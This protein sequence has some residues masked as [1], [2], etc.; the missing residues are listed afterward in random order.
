MRFEDRQIELSDAAQ[1]STA[2]GDSALPAATLA[3]GVAYVT[4]EDGLEAIDTATGK[5]TWQAPTKNDA[6]P[7]GFA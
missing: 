3:E 5:V 6:T 1:P 7:G 2:S 4:S